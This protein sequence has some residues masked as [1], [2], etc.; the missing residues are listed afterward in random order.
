MAGTSAREAPS[1]SAVSGDSR[2][3]RIARDTTTVAPRAA[4]LPAPST[5]SR[6]SGSLRRMI[7]SRYPISAMR[8]TPRTP[9][10]VSSAWGSSGL[11][12]EARRNSPSGV[13]TAA[14]QWS[15]LCTKIPLRSAMPPSRTVS[16]AVVLT[17]SV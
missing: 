5:G 17:F 2:L 1:S 3:P 4:A 10:T 16:L 8:S 14:A 7:G 6:A 15:R 9:G 13:R 12:P 11:R